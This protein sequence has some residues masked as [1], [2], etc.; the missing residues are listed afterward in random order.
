MYLLTSVEQELTCLIPPQASVLPNAFTAITCHTWLPQ[1]QNLNVGT[2][3]RHI[4]TSTLPFLI[5]DPTIST[6]HDLKR[7]TNQ[8][9]VTALILTLF[10]S[11]VDPEKCSLMFMKLPVMT[12]VF[13]VK[14]EKQGLPTERA[15][16]ISTKDDLLEATGI[17]SMSSGIRSTNYLVKSNLGFLLFN[18][19]QNLEQSPEMEE[20]APIEAADDS[21]S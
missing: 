4:V 21:K 18:D 12:N 7:F 3:N 16:I 9:S 14:I 13:K 15:L 11:Y 5:I 8:D 17:K 6:L 10:R 20:E 2:V 1:Q 19:N